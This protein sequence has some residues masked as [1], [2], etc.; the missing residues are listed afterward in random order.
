MMKTFVLDTNVL[1]HNP[2]GALPSARTTR[3]SFRSTCSRSWTN[4]RPT[5]DDTRPQRPHGHPACSISSA[6]KATC[7][8]A[9]RSSPHGGLL[10]IVLESND[11]KAARNCAA[12]RP[13]TASSAPRYNPQRARQARHLHLQGHQ[14]PHQGDALGLNAEDFEAQKVDF[15]HALHGLPRTVCSV[16]RHRR[17]VSQQGTSASTTPDNDAQ[18]ARQRVRAVQGRDERH[19]HGHRA[20][21]AGHR[22]RHAAQEPPRA[23]VFGLLPRNVQQTMALDL[24][25]DDSI[26]LVSLIGSAG[27]GKTLLALAA[28][29]N[30]VLNDEGYTKLLCA[31][32]IMPPGPRHRLPARRQGREARRV[33]AAD[34]RQRGLP[35]KQPHQRRPRRQAARAAQHRRAAHRT[36]HA[37]RA[38]SSSSR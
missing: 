22:P 18:A 37:V 10:K 8:R 11:R 29:M 36:A 24:L 7:S 4:S 12:T 33:D 9:S 15:E 21:P 30:K 28:G 34:F 16:G 26:K 31:R 5:S 13:T 32:P 1:L 20:L 23:P 27:T 38:R 2:N 17:A 19:A 14:R 25:L 35:A 3:S 6:R